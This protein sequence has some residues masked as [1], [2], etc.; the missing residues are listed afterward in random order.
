MSAWEI[1]SDALIS[2]IPP[3][4]VGGLFWLIMR[5]IL[6]VDQRERDAYAQIEAEERAKRG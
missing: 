2:L 3:I 6:R 4:L 1:L 5:S